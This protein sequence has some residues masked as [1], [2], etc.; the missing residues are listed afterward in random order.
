MVHYHRRGNVRILRDMQ[1]ERPLIAVVDDE[2]SVRLALA[3]LLRASSYQ[4]SLFSNGKDF[5]ASVHSSKPHCV[6]LDFQMP[7]MTGR[8]I[9]YALRLAKLA[10]P[11]IMMTAYDEPTLREKC[12][13]DGAIAYFAKP[14]RREDLMSAIDRA[15][16]HAPP[17]PQDHR[18]VT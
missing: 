18:G 1:D 6:V 9:Q 12:L 13:A 16:Q 15:V 11:V 17:Q 2:Q 14:L 5:L 4:V 10:I 8:D 3:R 7:D